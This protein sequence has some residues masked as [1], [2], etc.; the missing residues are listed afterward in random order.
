[1]EYKIDK[2]ILQSMLDVRGA[3]YQYNLL[4]SKMADLQKEICNISLNNN[5]LN[6]NIIEKKH[7]V[8]NIA[9]VLIMIEQL[10]AMQEINNNE[11]QYDIHNKLFFARSKVHEELENRKKAYCET[12]RDYRCQFDE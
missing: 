8:S 4:L 10:I 1:M 11:I 12:E 9:C 6:N 2:D 3:W 7:L 5:S